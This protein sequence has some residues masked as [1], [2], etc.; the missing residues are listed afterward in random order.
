MAHRADKG[1]A[2]AMPIPSPVTSRLTTRRVVAGDEAGM[3]AYV[4]LQTEASRHD[5]PNDPPPCP[6]ATLASF[7]H[8][9][10]GVIDEFWL[11]EDD[12]EV[13]GLLWLEL[14]QLDNTGTAVVGIMVS[15]DRRREGVGSALLAVA[16]ERARAHGRVRL[17]AETVQ[18]A[19]GRGA[20]ESGGP[21]F[22]TA[23]GAKLVLAEARRQLTVSD[24]DDAAARAM[25]DRAR[26]HADGYSIV[27]WSGP[28][29]EQYLA[30]RAYLES[31]MST[32]PPLGELAWEPEAF[33]AD[34]M[35]EQ[36]AVL[37]RRGFRSYTTGARHDA[38]GRLVGVTSIIMATSIDDYGYQWETIVDPEHRGHR[39]GWLIKAENFLL[40]RRKEP[41]VRSIQTWNADVNA[42][43]LAIN[44]AMGFRQL[45]V[46]AEW[47][48]DLAPEAG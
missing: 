12:T 26:A 37:Q 19:P 43:M 20:L 22:A 4:R 9:L 47:Q 44:D 46:A 1:F 42:P 16:R 8:T 32:D 25:A 39:L 3:H 29:P 24:F 36:Q 40:V 23:M 15:P 28:A 34:R 11:A 2:E 41:R 35:R 18:P 30:D 21:A 38:T 10:P 27:Q 5:L 13:V 48:L 7:A 33:D 45:D 6:V 31:R 14:P 17:V